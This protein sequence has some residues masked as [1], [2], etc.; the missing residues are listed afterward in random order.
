MRPRGS[1]FK[2]CRVEC[3]SNV[4]SS[5][6]RC[7]VVQLGRNAGAWQATF[8][9]PWQAR[10]PRVS[11]WRR[12]STGL[13][14]GLNGLERA[15]CCVA[16][17]WT[18]FLLCDRFV[19]LGKYMQIHF[20]YS[21]TDV[22]R[23][24]MPVNALL[25]ENAAFVV[26]SMWLACSRV[27]A[28]DCRIFL[29]RHVTHIQMK[30]GRPCA[31]HN[32]RYRTSVQEFIWRRHASLRRSSLRARYLLVHQNIDGPQFC[33][34]Q[35]RAYARETL[36]VTSSLAQIKYE[37]FEFWGKILLNR[38]QSFSNKKCTFFGAQSS[39]KLRKKEKKERTEKE[40][41]RRIRRGG[42]QWKKKKRKKRETYLWAFSLGLQDYNRERFG[43]EK[44]KVKMS[45]HAE[46][47][48]PAWR[49]SSPRKSEIIRDY[50]E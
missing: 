4:G 3:L 45:C 10:L 9:F 13:G 24:S 16:S 33:S 1:N 39:L 2:F 44:E 12:F 6:V 18:G 15:R 40:R 49:K 41:R 43:S 32:W 30:F 46:G 27:S 28:L 8:L 25:D 20:F 26:V 17:I 38:A 47:F 48:I 14:A 23:T 34:T 19:Y 36:R 11:S 35:F 42:K 5:F 37:F 29:F 7:H 31:V 50:S 22:L 21:V